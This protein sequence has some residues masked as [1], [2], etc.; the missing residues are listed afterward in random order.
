[1]DFITLDNG[2]RI[3]GEPM[4]QS[5]SVAVGVWIGAGSLNETEE[6]NGSAHFIEHMLFKGTERRNALVLAQEAD[7]LGGQGNAYTSKDCTCFYYRA[8]D[9]HLS[10]VMDLVGD[11]V[12]HSLLDPEELEREKG[13]ICEEI[14]M[15]QD[16][17]EDLVYEQM[18]AAYFGSDPAARPIL[19][20]AEK[21]RSYTRENLL[22]FYRKYYT[23]RN[24]VLSVAGHYD[25][26]EVRTLAEKIFGSMPAGDVRTLPVWK[27]ERP[28]PYVSC[29]KDIEQVHLCLGFPG[30]NIGAD[31]SAAH[32]LLHTLFGGGMSSRLFQQ[33]RERS[34]MAYSVYSFSTAHLGRGFGS[35]YAG[36]S[37]QNAQ[38][39]LDMIREEMQAL[40]TREITKTEFE[41]AR[42]QSKAGLILSGESVT[43]RMSAIGRREL[44]LNEYLSEDA[45]I[46]RVDRV[47]R[48][49]VL[50]AIGEILEGPLCVSVVGPKVTLSV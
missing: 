43:A 32:A 7:R 20:T 26:G 39:V 40:R 35:I 2:L 6:N 27:A 41:Q 45:I 25:L 23:A 5:R 22:S 4:P 19:G 21:I 14:D 34:G 9:T 44:L 42:E 11:Q 18:C 38:K 31:N 50:A 30:P 28:Q 16:T 49:D 13:V 8:L 24:C 36:C 48:E 15:A 17:P 33:I 46:A 10:D 37:V 12:L 3:I 29:V 47:T 1:M